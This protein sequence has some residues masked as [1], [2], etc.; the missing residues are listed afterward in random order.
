M[1]WVGTTQLPFGLMSQT[2]D[3]AGTDVIFV[4]GDSVLTALVRGGIYPAG[5][6][7][8]CCEGDC[9]YCIATV[10]GVSYVRTCQTAAREDLVVEPHPA[11][12]DP[13]LP[14]DQGYRSAPIEYRHADLVVVGQGESGRMAVYEASAAGRTVDAFDASSGEEVIGIYDGPMVIVR[15]PGRMIHVECD[16]IVVAT[17]AAQI[18]PACPGSELIGIITG[19]AAQVLATQGVELGVVAV[20]GPPPTDLECVVAVGELVRFEGSD[21]RLNAVVT[22]TDDGERRT[23]CDTAVVSL[24]IYPRDGLAR[25]GNGLAVTVVGDAALPATI[26]PCP[27][28]GVICPCNNVD[29]DDLQSVWDRGFHEMELVK[30]A[31]L[32]GTG[33]CQGMVCLPYLR[34]FLADRG[35]ELQPAFTAR[36]VARQLTIG[37]MSAGEHDRPVPRTPLHGEHVALGARMDRIG[38]WWRPWTYGDLAAEYDAVRHRV[39]IGDVSTLGKMIVSGPDAEAF[40]EYIYPTNVS[41]IKP[42]RSRYVLMLNERGYVFDDGLVSRELDG[43]FS[44]TFTSGGASHAEMWMRDWGSSYDVRMLNQTMSLAAIN[45][46]G[47]LASELL[48]KAGVTNPPPYMGHAEL[49]VAGIACKVYR[50]SFTG[51]LSFELHH[52]VDR[53]VELWRA[54]LELGAEY[55]I[56]PHGLEALQLLRLEK[57]HILVGVDTDFDSTPRRIQHEWACRLDKPD[58]LGKTAVVRTNEI[59]LDRLLVGFTTERATVD[60]ALLY[61]KGEYCGYV[62]S[63]G[64]SPIIG[65]GIAMA[66]LYVGSDGEL[67]DEVEI[68]GMPAVRVSLPFYDPQGGRAR[69]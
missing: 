1:G 57:G 6:G 9:P 51:E 55:D 7:T 11:D 4:E 53:S 24:G 52:P 27:S 33:T 63:A 64:W 39:S 8:L 45:V 56:Y 58:F 3:F 16:E 49:E 41:T 59:S 54:L 17:G 46:T 29:V 15:T 5:G 65:Q 21:G 20:V 66:W 2:F 68:D 60:G 22:V 37:E 10:D 40:L 30:R 47:P 31:T 12:Q 43:P 69:A 42:G 36:P 48:T 38:G 35:G 19:P 44:L 13:P 50:L 26:P 28:E 25:I 32:A 67:P 34:S 14:A 18:Q 61:S 62:T 23:E